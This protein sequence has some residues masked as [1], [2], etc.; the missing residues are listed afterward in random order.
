MT[1]R[2]AIQHALDQVA[3][4]HDVRILL[5]VESGSRAWGFP[6][7]DSDWDVRFIYVRPL[8]AYLSLSP[9]ADVIEVPLCNDLDL[10][11]WDLRKALGLAVKSNAVVLEWLGS[12][13]VYRHDEAAVAAIAGLARGSAHLPALAYH[14]D[15]LARRHWVPVAAGPVRLK[16][17]C[18]ALRPALALHWMRTHGTP[19]PMDVPALMAGQVS[20]L[21]VEVDALCRAKHDATEADAGIV[22]TA[23]NAFLGD[24]LASVVRRPT[25]WDTAPAVASANDLFR[26][27]LGVTQGA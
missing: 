10:S 26:S 19:P 15:R 13:I 21:R 1:M 16:S 9:V 2:A 4:E 6:S 17:L 3:H 27:L 23:I 8:A 24:V 20:P 18:Y 14:Y 12:P 7:R 25:R 22:G 11:G 5:A